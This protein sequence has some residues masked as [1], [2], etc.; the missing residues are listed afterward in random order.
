MRTY[1]PVPGTLPAIILHF[2][3][4][5]S[6]F[7]LHVESPPSPTRMWVQWK[8]INYSVFLGIHEGGR[9]FSISRYDSPT[10]SALFFPVL[11]ILMCRFTCKWVSVRKYTV[12]ETINVFLMQFMKSNANNMI[13]IHIWGYV[14]RSFT[15]F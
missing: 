11:C 13:Y 12:C 9:G 8:A 5:L 6:S 10:L 2:L 14:Q 1:T 7:H 4:H 15:H 3:A